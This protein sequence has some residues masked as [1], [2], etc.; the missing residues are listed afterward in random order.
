MPL[1]VPRLLHTSR[2]I[3][4]VKVQVAQAAT[5]DYGLDGP[6]SVSG[7]EGVEIFLHSFV[8]TQLPIK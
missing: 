3:L 1:Q 5:F 7:G 2:P 6:G 4:L 8:S